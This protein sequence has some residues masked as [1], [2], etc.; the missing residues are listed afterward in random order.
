MLAFHVRCPLLP[1]ELLL[2]AAFGSQHVRPE[3]SLGLKY[4]PFVPTRKSDLTKEMQEHDDSSVF[5]AGVIYSFL[6]LWA[7]LICDSV[8]RSI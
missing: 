7:P 3:G 4:R 5:A 6:T 2:L 8:F 1:V